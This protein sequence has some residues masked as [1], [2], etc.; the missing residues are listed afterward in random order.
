MLPNSRA[1]KETA[2][3]NLNSNWVLA[4][5]AFLILCLS[6]FASLVLIQLFTIIFNSLLN[7]AGPFVSSLIMVAPNFL[8]LM[9]NLP[10]IQGVVR[11][12]WL[13]QQNKKSSVVEVF[14]YYTSKDNIVK[15]ALLHLC[16]LSKILLPALLFFAPYFFVISFGKLEIFESLKNVLGIPPYTIQFISYLLVT[17]AVILSVKNALNYILAPVIY[18]SQ[19]GKD[20]DFTITLSKQIYKQNK[21]LFLKN[22]I[23]FFPLI[24][25]SCLGI[26]AFF[27]VPF[28]LMSY[29]TFARFSLVNYGI[30]IN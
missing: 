6:V 26:P 20:L 13:L 2:Q 25:L 5:A 12:F 27:T 10:L 24:A 30:K 4:I 1:I 16:L 14:Y 21:Q 18:L 28:V 19:E 9:F 15:S 17:A 23:A 29:A 3:K 7:S 8:L 11:F 22:L